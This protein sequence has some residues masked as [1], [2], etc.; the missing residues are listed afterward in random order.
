MI[1]STYAWT[2][3]NA[4]IWAKFFLCPQI[5]DLSGSWFGARVAS[6]TERKYRPN[7]TSNGIQSIDYG[8]GDDLMR[9]YVLEISTSLVGR[10]EPPALGSFLLR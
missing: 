5:L 6:V 2:D 10:D 8:F 7:A 4:I 9:A 3:R 1:Q